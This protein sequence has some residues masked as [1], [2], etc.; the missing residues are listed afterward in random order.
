[1]TEDALVLCCRA[2]RAAAESD[3]VTA[4][5]LAAVGSR[6]VHF[7]GARPGKA[8]DPLLTPDGSAHDAVG[9]PDPVGARSA[10]AR[11]LVLGED[12]DLA[13]VVL[14]LLRREL[15]ERLI[16][17]YVTGVPSQVTA[18]HS[19]PLGAAAVR[20]ALV[21]DPDLVVL[22]RDDNGGVL[23]GR[24]E[25]TPVEGTVYVDEFPLLR[26]R[27]AAVIVDP[28][29]AKG[30]EV[31]LLHR[32]MLTFGRRPRSR[33]GRAVEI[34]SR[35]PMTIVTDGVTRPRTV[36]HWTFYRH[37]VPLRLVRGVVE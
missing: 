25:L 5:G 27:A 35:V 34:G 30:V 19:L 10:T 29:Q 32:R 15:F 28:H 16:I 37:T 2:D 14:R 24:A 1:M 26:G 17:G 36:D 13:A 11:V 33:T 31:T 9:A 12:A 6:T 3:P 7:V 20:L 8:I 18:L 22:V 21:G 4:P 23:M